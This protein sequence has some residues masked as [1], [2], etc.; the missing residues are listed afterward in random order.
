MPPEVRVAMA[1]LGVI[2]TPP[3]A[4]VVMA[5]MVRTAQMQLPMQPAI[6]A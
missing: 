4:M 3:G 5:V 6:A 1:A 2:L